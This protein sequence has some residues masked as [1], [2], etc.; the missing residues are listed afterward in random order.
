MLV[1]SRYANSEGRDQLVIGDS[2]T[3]KVVKVIGDKVTLGVEAPD[4]V[5][6][7]RKELLTDEKQSSTNTCG[8]FGLRN[9]R[10]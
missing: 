8:R 5:L 3:I 10:R 6:V 9:L 1:L 7:I 4:N 2:I